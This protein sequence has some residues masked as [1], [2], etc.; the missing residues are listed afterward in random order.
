MT[1]T[2][3]AAPTIAGI[4]FL[5]IVARATAGTHTTE[6]WFIRFPNPNKELFWSI[7]FSTD[8]FETQ[9]GEHLKLTNLVRITPS[10]HEPQDATHILTIARTGTNAN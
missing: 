4:V 5:E 9:V 8:W 10:V 7:H 1:I 2:K 6:S 3:P